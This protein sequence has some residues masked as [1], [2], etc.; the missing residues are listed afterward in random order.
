MVLVRLG[1]VFLGSARIHCAGSTFFANINR[2]LD[3]FDRMFI[4]RR[5]AGWQ[6]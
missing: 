3:G 1:R 4:S 6:L 5:S 2:P